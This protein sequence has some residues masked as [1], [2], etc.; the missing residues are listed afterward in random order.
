M[1]NIFVQRYFILGSPQVLD[2]IMNRHFYKTF[3]K[4]VSPKTKATASGSQVAMGD[5]IPQ[6]HSKGLM[7]EDPLMEQ[8]VD[9]GD[10]VKENDKIIFS[11]YMGWD[12]H[13]ELIEDMARQLPKGTILLVLGFDMDDYP[14][15][16]G[17]QILEVEGGTGKRLKYQVC[18]SQWIAKYYFPLLY[19][20]L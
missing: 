9:S 19:K 12:M 17:G 13:A 6:W 14:N 7:E 1:P 11:S 20:Q 4:K 10:F 15:K 16:E 8:I 5:V 3:S 2:Q 18:P